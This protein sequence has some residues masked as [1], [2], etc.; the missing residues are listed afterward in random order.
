MTVLSIV[1]NK[2]TFG[3]VLQ[4]YIDDLTD[5]E[6]AATINNIMLIGTSIKGP[7]FSVIEEIPLLE[8]LGLLEIVKTYLISEKLG[9]DDEYDE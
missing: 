2:L 5:E 8:G 4:N 6:R 3:E 1:N 9:E 7:F